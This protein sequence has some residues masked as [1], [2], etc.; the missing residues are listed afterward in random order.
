MKHL[1]I[2]T[3]RSFVDIPVKMKRVFFFLVPS[4]QQFCFMNFFNTLQ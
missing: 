1:R 2:F 3:L 4:L